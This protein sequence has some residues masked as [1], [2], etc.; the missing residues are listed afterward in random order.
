M[1]TPGP[2]TAADIEAAAGNLLRLARV[3]RGWSQLQLAQAAGVPA[4]TVGRIEA[5]QRQPSVVTLTRLLAAADFDLRMRLEPYDDHDDVLDALAARRTPE[6]QAAV[7][8]RHEVNV[9]AFRSAVPVD[10]VGPSS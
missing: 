7:A 1:A 9:Q 3:Q 6:E 4:S 10:S 5:G 2:T 8:A